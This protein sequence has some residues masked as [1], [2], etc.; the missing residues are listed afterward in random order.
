[1]WTNHWSQDNVMFW[2][3][4]PESHVCPEDKDGEWRGGDAPVEN[5]EIVTKIRRRDPGDPNKSNWLPQSS[6]YIWTISWRK[7]QAF[8]LKL[9]HTLLLL[10]DVPVGSLG[11]LATGVRILRFQSHSLDQ[12]FST[13]K[14][15]SHRVGMRGRQLNIVKEV[16]WGSFGKQTMLYTFVK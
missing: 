1:M 11:I 10:K 16:F 14:D 5:Y 3:S 8:P 9:M 13:R 2:W 12:W 4:R 6:D 15:T 7:V